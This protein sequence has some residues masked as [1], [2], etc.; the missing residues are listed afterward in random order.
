MKKTEA[1]K[2]LRVLAVPSAPEAVGAAYEELAALNQSELVELCRLAELRADRSIPKDDL[3]QMI[4]EGRQAHL[5]SPRMNML[6]EQLTALLHS[7][8]HVR[9]PPEAC[10]MVCSKCA[11]LVVL[12][13]Y[14]DRGE[15]A[16][17]WQGVDGFVRFVDMSQQA[18]RSGVEAPGDGQPGSR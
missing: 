6:R 13:C 10:P 4:L 5:P 17:S 14:R 2:E 8:A 16:R 7:R 1:V 11:D 15:W 12:M 9:G 18:S 3:I